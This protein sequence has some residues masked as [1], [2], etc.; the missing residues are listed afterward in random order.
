MDLRFVITRR[1]A[2]FLGAA[3][4]LVGRSARA[5]V[6]TGTVDYR[7]GDTVLEGYLAYD[8]TV[9]EKR[10]GVIVF[11]TK[12]GIGDFIEEK[13]RD[14]AAL[15]YV[16]L[17]GD[18]YG[19]GVR[20]QGDEESS[21][22]SAKYKKDRKLTRLRVKAAFDLLAAN[23]RVDASRIAVT[24][25]CAGGM[26]GLEL[27]R[28]GAPIKAAAIFHG[29][30]ATP[31]PADAKN[32]KGRVLV[33]H[34][35]DDPTAPLSEVQGLIKE[36]KDARVDFQLEL[37]GGVRHGFTE[38]KNGHDLT[39]STAYDERADRESWTAMKALFQETLGR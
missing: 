2:V 38:P 24:G 33:M 12:R 6:R 19:K 26:F 1:F 20:P 17:A 10:P 7:Q 18:V 8:E 3:S 21:A 28:M 4:F 23:P 13:V 36:M 27:A 9:A 30:L 35:A 25:Y 31:T 15:G 32:I 22:E 11:H 5:A 14:L 29:S 39:K 34:G 37:Y 16:A